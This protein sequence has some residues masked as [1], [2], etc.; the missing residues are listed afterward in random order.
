VGTRPKYGLTASGKLVESS[1][2][3]RTRQ[4]ERKWQGQTHVARELHKAYD[5]SDTDPETTHMDTLSAYALTV[6]TASNRNEICKAAEHA[7]VMTMGHSLFT[8]MAFDRERMEVE[9]FYTSDPENY[10]AGGRKKKRDT[11]WGQFVLLDGQTYIGANDEDIRRNFDDH[12]II[13]GLGLCSVINIPIK[14]MGVTIG[15]MNLLDT[16]A[17]YD[18]RDACMGAII[19]MGLVSAIQ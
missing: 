2:F 7:A 19:A 6:A 17:H 13:A 9:R 12:E 5:M 15:T 11:D 3:D 4:L 14:R 8:V 1:Q 18:E 10:P 16:T